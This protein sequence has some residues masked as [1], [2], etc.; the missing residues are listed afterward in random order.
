MILTN[1]VQVDLYYEAIDRDF[2]IYSIT[3]QSAKLDRTN[4]L[5]ISENE[6]KA[7]SVQYTFGRKAFVLFKKNSVNEMAFRER[8]NSEYDDVRIEHV[9]LSDLLDS[10]FCSQNFYYG[11]RLLIQLLLNSLMNT[12]TE[13]R[14]YNNLTGKLFYSNGDMFVKDKSTG[15][16]AFMSFVEVKLD[17]GMFLNMD[18]KTY[19][20]DR[21]GKY[22][23]DRKTGRL[24]KRLKSDAMEGVFYSEGS[25]KNKH[26]TLDFLDIS[27]FDKFQ[28][29]KLGIMNRFLGDV[30]RVLGKY[31]K[32]TL[33]EISD[34][35][36]Y[37]I[38]KKE[39]KG[40]SEKEI[41]EFLNKRGVVIVDE[42]NTEKS[43]NI[44]NRLKN[45]LSTYY[46]VMTEEGSLDSKKYNIRIIHAPEFYEEMNLQDP[47]NINTSK[48]IVQHLMEEVEHFNEKNT[49]SPAI[50][51]IVQELIIK[52]DVRDRKISIYDWERLDSDKEW[53]FVTRE[54]VRSSFDGKKEPHINTA[55]KSVYDYYN[56]KVLKI[57][58]GGALSFESFSDEGE[59]QG[60]IHESIC[61]AFDY[62]VSQY[63]GAGNTVEGLVFSDVE[64]IHA[65]LLTPEKTIPNISAIAN[66]LKETDK[67]IPISCETLIDGIDSFIEYSGL[68]SDELAIMK[69]FRHKLTEEGNTIL[70]LDVR[71]MLGMGK[72]LSK[73][74]NRYMHENYN[75]WISA[76]IKDQ[77][78]ED[79]YMLE[80]V[81][82]IKY[83]QLPDYEETPSFYYYVGTKRASLQGSIH[84]ACAIRKVVSYS[85]DIEFSELLPLMAV[86]FVRNKQYTVLPFPFKYLR[87]WK[88]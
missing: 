83:F 17:P 79:I 52:G 9:T 37:E 58:Q 39:K 31:M 27:S 24:R 44:V 50:N 42:N 40:L 85:G 56:Y 43:Q 67:S 19:R 84:N 41:G 22:L 78:F 15:E 33:L 45:E 72:K 68:S 64:N 18:V 59:I 66:G 3:K 1:K 70:T 61:Y 60:D 32:V 8:I 63:N 73:L 16:I 2:D 30:E 34:G 6:F 12:Q 7:V 76:E 69:E 21:D 81:L 87:E 74:F 55:G 88:E 29:S 75:V 38:S 57:V 49:A 11:N 53:S 20:R 47:H 36:S 23:V 62:Y 5:D 25:Y 86:D 82:D 35:I 26:K 51:K 54:K 77:D 10:D 80:S 65:I 4:I 71:K 14:A 13:T 46:G 28:K 48:Y